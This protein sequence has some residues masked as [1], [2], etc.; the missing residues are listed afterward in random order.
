MDLNK[1]AQQRKEFCDILFELAKSQEILQ[2]AYYRVSMYKRLEAL[3]DAPL[4]D[5]RFRHFYSDIFSVLTQIQ[6]NPLLGD[7]N[8][9]GQNLS[10]I[11]SG[12]QPRNR[13]DDGER[14]IDVSDALKKLYDHVNLDIARIS[15]SDAGD[16]KISGEEA[17]SELQTQ[18]KVLQRDVKKAQKVKEDFE[19]TESKIAEVENKLESSQ[20]FGLFY[21]IDRLVNKSPSIKPL[22][23]SNVVLVALLSV[24][25]AAWS[26]G[27][28]E[29][30]DKRIDERAGNSSAV[31][32]IRTEE[33]NTL[34]S[35]E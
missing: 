12:Y 33:L 31:E 24:T 26:M 9:L 32:T 17:V 3:Y 2:D 34:E 5:K 20:K 4:P 23:I 29:S 1:E 8:I 6:Q 21:Y 15:Y 14:I 7:T 35:D 25:M 11:R 18:V 28:V 10:V 13:A 19:K 22:I 16:R 30:R 27:W